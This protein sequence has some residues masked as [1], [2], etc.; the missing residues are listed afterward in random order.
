[1]LADVRGICHVLRAV[2]TEVAGGAAPPPP[3]IFDRSVNPIS[4]KGADYAHQIILAPRIFR[5]SDSPGIVIWN[6]V[7][8]RIKLSDKKLPL[9]LT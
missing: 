4:T 6:I 7:L 2:N 1:M 9:A 5:P 3:P 8:S